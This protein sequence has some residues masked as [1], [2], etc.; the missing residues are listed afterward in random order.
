MLKEYGKELYLIN[1]VKTG[2]NSPGETHLESEY[3]KAISFINREIIDPQF[4]FKYLH[5]DMKN[6]LKR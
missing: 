6:C 2:E 1:L 3:K 5:L 4:H